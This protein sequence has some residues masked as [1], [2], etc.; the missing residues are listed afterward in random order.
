MVTE[1]ERLT[2]GALGGI[3][4]P[5]DMVTDDVQG[6]LITCYREVESVRRVEKRKTKVKRML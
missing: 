1:C 5:S 6:M 2:T 3:I 4:S